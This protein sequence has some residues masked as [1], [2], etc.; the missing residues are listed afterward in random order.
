MSRSLGFR[1]MINQL[2]WMSPATKTAA[3]KK[4]D[5]LVVNIGYPEWITNDAKLVEAHE[6]CASI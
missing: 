5:H 3:Y 1:S 2:N 6:V 4:I